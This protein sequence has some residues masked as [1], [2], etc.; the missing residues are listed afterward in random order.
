MRQVY[1][2]HSVFSRVKLP[3]IYRKF[4]ELKCITELYFNIFYIDFRRPFFGNLPFVGKNTH[5]WRSTSKKRLQNLKNRLVSVN[6]GL[7][8]YRQFTGSLPS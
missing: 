3:N 4:T 7:Q 8:I 5:F 2:E 1:I 6:F